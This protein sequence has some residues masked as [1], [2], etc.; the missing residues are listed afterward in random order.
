MIALALSACATEDEPVFGE[1]GRVA[2]GFNQGQM[3]TGPCEV[4]GACTV[5]W[6]NNL[7]PQIFAAELGGET[8][9]GACGEA[10]CHR[11]GAGGLRFPPDNENDAYFNL[12]SYELVGGRPYIV[13]CHPEQSH[14]MCNLRFADGVINDYVGPEMELTGGC[15]SPMPKP[16]ETV[17]TEPLDQDQ[18]NAIAEWITCGAPAN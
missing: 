4:N 15:G 5:S 11:E 12:T 16:T 9:S 10:E 17:P 14:I 1:P 8:P 6:S 3:T 18:L 13:G 7:Y 2:G